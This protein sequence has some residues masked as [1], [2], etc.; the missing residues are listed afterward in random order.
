MAAPEYVPLK[1][2]DP[3]HRS[4]TSPDYVPDPWRPD[5]PGELEG[6]QPRG[7]RLGNQGPDQGFALLLA[8]R[9]GDRLRLTPGEHADDV[10]QGCVSIALRRASLFGRAPMVH[11]LTIAFTIWGFLDDA[12]PAAL[13]ALRTKAFEGLGHTA[14]HYD[15][16][17]RLVDGV[18]EATL[19]MTPD[20]VKAAYPSRWRELLGLAS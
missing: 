17:R 4:Y 20:E 14:H 10:I 13:V 11:D 15:E 19:R 8:E 12:A 9:F 1:R 5:R 6:G 3:A 16:L 2:V 18:S 7:A